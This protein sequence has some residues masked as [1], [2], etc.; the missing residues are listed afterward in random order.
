M[1]HTFARDINRLKE[2]DRKARQQGLQNLMKLT[3]HSASETQAYFS[4]VVR[5]PLLSLLGE[6]SEANKMLAI[7]LL[8]RLVAHGTISDDDALY[9]F[10]AVFTRLDS[11][12]FPEAAEEVRL[13]L[14]QLLNQMLERYLDI[15]QPLMAD[16]CN[17]L[18][19]ACQD[20]FPNSKNVRAT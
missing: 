20:S 12:P 18:S 19:R 4:T 17:V 1:E 8:K 15:T 9:V 11:I 5:K 13:A 14:L 6:P 2:Q 16:L 10:Q 7:S 3:E